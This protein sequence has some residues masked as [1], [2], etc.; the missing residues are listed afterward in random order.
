MSTVTPPVAIPVTTPASPSRK[1]KK[2]KKKKGGTSCGG[3]GEQYHTNC[4]SSPKAEVKNGPETSLLQDIVPG[5]PSINPRHP[6]NIA[7]DGPHLNREQKNEKLFKTVRGILN[8]LTPQ[9]FAPLVK[10][11]LD[12]NIDSEDQLKGVA[13]MVFETAIS[14]PDFSEMYANLCESEDVHFRKFLS[15]CCQK[16][17]EA[18]AMLE[19]DFETQFKQMEAIEDEKQKAEA[20]EN[21]HIQTAKAKQTYLGNIRFM[22]DLFKLHSLWPET[23]M[24]DC[25]YKLLTNKDEKKQKNNEISLEVNSM[26]RQTLNE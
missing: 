22:G 20:E 2:R 6:P 14:Q 17:F 4:V 19:T 7:L 16:K 15:N 18:G 1:K 9:K 3:Q 21:Y 8:K 26:T 10:Q 23:I 24:H 5:V 25:L 11:I 12:L 13:E